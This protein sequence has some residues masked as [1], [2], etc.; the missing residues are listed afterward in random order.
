MIGTPRKTTI[1][2]NP[3]ANRTL[4]KIETKYNP[5]KSNV[6][7][8][9][10][11]EIL[12]KRCTVF[13]KDDVLV[14]QLMDHDTRNELFKCTKCNNVHS[15]NQIRYALKMKLPEYIHYNR[16][17]KITDINKERQEHEKFIIEPINAQSPSDLLRKNVVKAVKNKPIGDL[18]NKLRK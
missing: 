14:K 6:S 11:V 9:S 3:T 2:D 18:D 16:A 8:L 4:R 7:D 15:E 10:D 1:N 13:D 17:K 5:I 12:C